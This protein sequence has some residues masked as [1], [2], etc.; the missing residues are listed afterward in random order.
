M[1][2][3]IVPFHSG[4]KLATSDG[5]LDIRAMFRHFMAPFSAAVPFEDLIE[6]VKENST[7]DVR[8][9]RNRR[10][11][12]AIAIH[13]AVTNHADAVREAM[14][15]LS[16]AMTAPNEENI[17]GIVGAM[18]MVFPN[19]QPTESSGYLIDMLVLELR[20]PEV[21]YPFCLPAIAAA[22]RESWTTLASPPSIAEFV[23]RARKHESRIEAVMHELGDVLEAYYWQRISSTRSGRRRRPVQHEAGARFRRA[24]VHPSQLF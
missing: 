19:A 23:A 8:R 22:A 9:C 2:T 7:A 11:G 21:G 6:V 20:E 10:P 17:R 4:V 24:L 3:E 16:V 12:A 1:T 15:H 13:R 18:M 14:D 5:R